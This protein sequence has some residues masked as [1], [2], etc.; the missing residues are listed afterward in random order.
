MPRGSKGKARKQSKQPKTP[1]KNKQQQKKKKRSL[2]PATKA[3]LPA[4]TKPPTE[5]KPPTETQRLVA[6]KP[7]AAT[8]EPAEGQV[9][10]EMEEVRARIASNPGYRR[11]RK[12]ERQRWKKLAS[13]KDFVWETWQLKYQLGEFFRLDPDQ[14]KKYFDPSFSVTPSTLGAV[15]RRISSLRDEKLKALLTRYTRYALLYDVAL[16]LTR[17]NYFQTRSLGFKGTTY[18]VAVRSGQIRPIADGPWEEKGTLPLSKRVKP[19]DWLITGAPMSDGFESEVPV[20]SNLQSLLGKGLARYV[21]IEDEDKSSILRQILDFA[22]S[23][24]QVTVIDYASTKFFLVG[25]NVPLIDVWSDL[26]KV[27]ADSQRQIGDGD[28]RG[29]LPKLWRVHGNLSLIVRNKGSL[30]DKAQILLRKE[31]RERKEKEDREGKEK[32]KDPKPQTA[33][34]RLAAKQSYLSQLKRQLRN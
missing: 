10:A 25:E 5:A 1:A 14:I 22:Y 33:A 32:G 8:P 18:H 16:V 23:P 19:G 17:E 26:R 12:A 20:P 28:Q 13:N 2:S 30:G 27:A 24:D 31:D 9:D 7:P 11:I 6:E 15:R 3:A 34:A 21:L 4:E 29:R